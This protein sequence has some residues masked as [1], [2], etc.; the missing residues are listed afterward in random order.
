MISFCSLCRISDSF[1]KKIAE[2][3]IS[4]IRLMYSCPLSKSSNRKDCFASSA[5][6]VCDTPCASFCFHNSAGSVVNS[7]MTG[8]TDDI[9]RFCLG[10]TGYCPSLTSPTGRGYVSSTVYTT[11][12]QNLIYKMRTVNAACQG[13]AAPYIWVSNKLVCI[14]YDRASGRAA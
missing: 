3:F 14:R 2:I 10:K 4:A 7:Y 12:F 6:V 11:V 13:I 5:S 9:A 8:I 1:H